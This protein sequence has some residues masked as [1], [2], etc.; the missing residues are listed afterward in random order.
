[1]SWRDVAHKD[2]HDASRSRT[3]WLLSGFLG[4]VFVGFAVVDAHLG[5][6]GFGSFLEGTAGLA[7][8]LLP[9]VAILAGY[10]SI[11][12]GRADGSLFLTLSLPHSR[13]DLVVGTFLGRS[14]VVL[15]PTTVA[16]AVAGVV[17]VG[18]HGSD[19]A[20]AYP[21][22]L[23][24]TG[25]YGLAFVGFAIGLSMSTT[26]DRWITLGAVGGYLLLVVAWD[27]V[28]SAT[29][30]ILH[31]FDVGVLADVPDWALLFRLASPSESYVRLVGAGFDVGAAARYVG[32]VPVYVDWWMALL[33]L[34]AWSLVPLSVGYRRFRAAD[35]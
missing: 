11:V 30:L 12:D 2:V 24:A 33:V 3:I 17:G 1:M 32:D 15:A 4:V 20:L 31:R 21:W 25:V 8:V 22:F 16:L 9:G 5:R 10:K 18:L 7:A 19:G 28:H 14:I 26:V 23:F 29:L 35:L 13:R 34:V 27:T 6:G